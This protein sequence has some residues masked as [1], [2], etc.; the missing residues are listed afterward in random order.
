MLKEEL[1]HLGSLLLECAELTAVPAGGAL[2][3]DRDAF[4]QLVTEKITAHPNI[5]LIREEVKRIPQDGP[6]IIASGPL[7]SP[8]LSADI[9]QWSGQDNLFFFDAIAPIIA[10]DSLNMDIAFRASRY[11][12]GEQEQ[13]DYINAPLNKEEY[14]HFVESL[15]KA[16]RIVLREFEAE[17]QDGVRAGPAAFLKAACLWK[18][19][20]SRG[21]DALA[22]GP[23]RPVGLR[24][25]RTGKTPAR[26][27]PTPSG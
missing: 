14:D 2:A 8:A 21:H 25:P 7:T 24:D 20:A 13:G 9:H 15:L 6:V 3:V 16:E 23:M 11:D 17:L 26:R 22:Y 27:P 18:I 10:V 4:S 5:S 12:R 19:I 1:R